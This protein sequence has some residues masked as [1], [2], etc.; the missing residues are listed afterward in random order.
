MSTNKARVTAGSRPVNRELSEQFQRE[1][2]PLKDDLYRIAL[3][4]TGR[5]ADAE[6]LVQD[7]LTR[8]FANFHRYDHRYA[9]AWLTTIMRNAWISA[10]RRRQYRPPEVL[11][12]HVA[13]DEGRQGESTGSLSA[14]QAALSRI[15]SGPA[16]SAFRELSEPSRTVMYYA[17]I[18]GYPYQEIA[19]TLDVP[20]GTVMSRLHRS[21]IRLRQVLMGTNSANRSSTNDEL[22]A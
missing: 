1:I 15:P 9:K 10:Y 18:E 3:R 6:D 11:M 5:H 8:A 19:D 14:E 13:D 4:M 22:R 7:T 17:D 12:G 2:W 21:R 20:V 16:V